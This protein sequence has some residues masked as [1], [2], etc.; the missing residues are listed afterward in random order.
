MIM[1]RLASW[2][3]I[4]AAV[5]A[6]AL[7]WLLPAAV[8][9]LLYANDGAGRHLCDCRAWSQ[10]VDGLRGPNVPWPCRILRHRRLH[11]RAP[12]YQAGPR[13]LDRAAV[14][15]RASGR[16]RP[17]AC[18]SVVSSGGSL[19]GDGDDRVRHHR[20]QRARRMERP[21]RRHAG[22]AQHSPSD[23]RRSASAT[24]TSIPIDCRSRSY[25]SLF[26]C[27]T[28]CARPGDALWS[29]CAKI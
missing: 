11:R 9:P 8:R 6:I 16:G 29:R 23:D 10:L 15:S 26:C 7:A 14:F 25:W 2:S 12:C 22:R 5:A 4:F 17:S 20:Q 1:A 21:H 13:L 24:R 19:S 27:A 3:W 28:S 18:L